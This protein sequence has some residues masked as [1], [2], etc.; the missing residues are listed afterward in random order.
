MSFIGEYRE[1]ITM[2][3]LILFEGVFDLTARSLAKRQ[4]QERRARHQR[5]REL[6]ASSRGLEERLDAVQSWVDSRQ[7]L[8]ERHQQINSQTKDIADFHRSMSHILR[9]V[10]Q[11]ENR[12]LEDME[13][14]V[15]Q[16]RQEKSLPIHSKREEL[17][18]A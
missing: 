13:S 5:L 12:I 2:N 16:D 10:A 1:V 18:H 6:A 3:F 17:T 11:D 8:R 4:I 15:D 9:A 14:V 7:Q